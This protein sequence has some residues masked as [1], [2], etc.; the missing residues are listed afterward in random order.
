MKTFKQYLKEAAGVD[1]IAQAAGYN[2]RAFHGTK[3]RGFTVFNKGNVGRGI[4]GANRSGG[5]YFSSKREGAEYFADNRL[6]EKDSDIELSNDD[7][8]VYG[9]GP[10]F[11]LI[12]DQSHFDE[13][14]AENP[15]EINMGPYSTEI[16]ATREGRVIVNKWNNAT[17]GDM[18]YE[19]DGIMDVFLKMDN[20]H[21]VDNINDMRTSEPV[22]RKNGYDGIIAKDVVDGDTVADV[23]I[24]FNPS[25]IK[26]ADEV[27]YDNQ[28]RIIPITN[29]F[30]PANPDIRY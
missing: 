12:Q 30:N 18:V 19:D 17:I 15:V 4:V 13:E 21:I 16:D 24:V 9:D 3:L 25:Q 14:E 2:I 26:S 11:V 20:P 5:F 8:Q 6:I 27:T 10:F 29:R 7:I 22:A 1:N 23:Y 28:G